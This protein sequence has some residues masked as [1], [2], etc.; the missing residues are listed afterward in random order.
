[1]II[2]DFAYK[3]EDPRH[4]GP[5]LEVTGAPAKPKGK[6]RAPSYVTEAKQTTPEEEDDEPVEVVKVQAQF[7]FD[8][9]VPG[10]LSFKV[11]PHVCRQQL[12]RRQTDKRRHCNH[13]EPWRRVAKRHAQRGIRLCSREVCES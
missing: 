4:A 9:E 8:T 12:T 1:V 5:A 7:D 10:E 6:Q 3:T 13:R 2:R 11:Q